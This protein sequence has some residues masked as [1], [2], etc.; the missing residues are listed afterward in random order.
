MTKRQKEKKIEKS[1]QLIAIDMG[2]GQQKVTPEQLWQHAVITEEQ[3]SNIKVIGI[4]IAKCVGV[5]K[6]HDL[7]KFP[8]PFKDN[9]VYAIFA[10]HFVE[11]LDG[12]ERMKF[13]NE[14]YRIL[15]KGASMKLIHPYNWSN[16]AFQDPTHKSFINADSYFYFQKEWR[17]IN[18]LDH[19]PIY[20]DFEVFI[21]YSWMDESWGLKSEDVRNFASR[22]Y[23]NVISDLFVTLKKR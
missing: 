11:H 13:M 22:N 14:C 7:T 8:Y 10:S 2:C 20:C 17:K 3:K 1:N 4:D 15:K 19:Y 6:V 16:R 18:K 9:S 5:D 12:T 21:S 23:V